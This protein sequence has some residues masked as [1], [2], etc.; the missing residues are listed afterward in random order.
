VIEA[1]QNK[2]ATVGVLPLP[3]RDDADPWWR[4]LVAED[5]DAP[6]IIARLPFTRPEGGSYAEALAICP[7]AQEP[8]GR[9]CTYIA[10][11][12]EGEIGLDQ[13]GTALKRSGLP[14]AYT[15]VWHDVEGPGRWVYLAEVTDY[16]PPDDRRLERLFD[17][18]ALA[19]TRIIPLGGYATPLEPV[20]LSVE[21][22][23][24]RKKPKKTGPG[25]KP[26]KPRKKAP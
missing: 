18:F 8:T 25:S 19:N 22:P 21:A 9:D 7:L 14:F 3:W 20:E 5:R 11:E 10:I 16:L 4:Y 15:S 2:Q 23:V 6:R 1:V 24:R 13:L 17:H 26:A 12:A